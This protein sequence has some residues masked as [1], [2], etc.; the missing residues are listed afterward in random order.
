MPPHGRL[1]KNAMWTTRELSVPA[2]ADGRI[3][4]YIRGLFE[5]DDHEILVLTGSVSL[6][7]SLLFCLFSGKI[8][9]SLLVV[10]IPAYSMVK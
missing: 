1:H 7:G 8:D 2:N 3:D 9:G 6:P 4:S 5:N 10:C